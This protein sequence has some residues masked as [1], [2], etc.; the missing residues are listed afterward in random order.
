[1]GFEPSP[2]DPMMLMVTLG[3]LVNA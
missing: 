3:D 1:V 2:M